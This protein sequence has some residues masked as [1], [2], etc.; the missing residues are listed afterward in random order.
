VLGLPCL[1][2]APGWRRAAWAGGLAAALGAGCYLPFVLSGHFAMFEI[3]WT[4]SGG[5]LAALAGLDRVT[6]WLRL[7]QGAVVAAGVALAA[8]RYRAQRLGFVVVPLVA[9]L[10]RVATDPKTLPYYWTSV[11]VLALWLFALLPASTPRWRR[12]VAGGLGYL[13]LLSEAANWTVAGSLACLVLLLVAT[14]DKSAENVGLEV[15]GEG[16]ADSSAESSG[17]AATFPGSGDTR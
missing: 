1:L 17:L 6:W 12:A 10:L 8:R 5:T 3:R 11:A 9:A 15:A 2:A 13:S 14:T 16:G 7:A 4:V